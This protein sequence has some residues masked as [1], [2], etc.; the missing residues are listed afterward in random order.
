MKAKPEVHRVEFVDESRPALLF[1]GDMKKLK[2][3]IQDNRDCIDAVYQLEWRSIRFWDPSRS[4]CNP[5]VT[6]SMTN[7]PAVVT[8]V[9]L[10]TNQIRFLL[11]M[12]M[13]CPLGHTEQYSY[14]HN[15][16]ASSLYNQLENC[17]HDALAELS[18]G[19]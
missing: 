18:E 6:A 10:D 13:G 3:Y 5:L 14:H 7:S 11:D 16:N 9:T 8:E 2:R 15:V 1:H 12:M 4:V 17:L 19:L